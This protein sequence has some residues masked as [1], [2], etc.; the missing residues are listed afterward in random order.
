MQNEPN[1]HSAGDSS[2]LTAESDV[3]AFFYLD[4]VAALQRL[5]DDAESLAVFAGRLGILVREA[6]VAATAAH[7]AEFHRATESFDRTATLTGRLIGC[8]NLEKAP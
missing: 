7:R 8:L 1:S 5:R 3:L 2:D 4:A 6:G